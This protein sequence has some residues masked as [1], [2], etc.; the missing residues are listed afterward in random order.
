MLPGG[1]FHGDF[2]V[3]SLSS[4]KESLTG[5]GGNVQIQRVKEVWKDKAAAFESPLKPLYDK[6]R[7]TISSG[8]EEAEHEFP[9]PSVDE[10]GGDPPEQ[11]AADSGSQEPAVEQGGVPPPAG[12]Q[13]PDLAPQ[14]ALGEVYAV[15]G[16]HMVFG[17]FIKTAPVGSKWPIDVFPVV[18]R[19]SSRQWR[20]K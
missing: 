11:P 13:E 1:R 5:D 2:S 12:A 10:P 15:D 16:G 19:D 8:Q 20:L 4:F 18:W 14:Q 7:R 9:G 17:V 6:T 3:A